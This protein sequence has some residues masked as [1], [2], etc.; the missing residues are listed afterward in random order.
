[1]CYF[2]NFW[3]ELMTMKLEMSDSH[4]NH[5]D[6]SCDSQSSQGSSTNDF[7]S[8]VPTTRSLLTVSLS[9]PN[10]PNTPLEISM[11]SPNY[12]SEYKVKQKPLFTKIL[13][14]LFTQLLSQTTGFSTF[15]HSQN[16][17]LTTTIQLNCW[18]LLKFDMKD[19]TIN[20]II[21]QYNT[22]VTS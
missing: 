15:N 19:I 10:I 3:R 17:V 1:M 6:F 2:L 18:Y 21:N 11:P 8:T 12:I 4:S 5:S 7:V 9:I 16:I 20:H 14:M 22:C 13:V